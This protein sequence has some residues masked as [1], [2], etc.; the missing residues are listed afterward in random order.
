MSVNT[1]EYIY[2]IDRVQ[3]YVTDSGYHKYGKNDKDEMFKNMQSYLKNKYGDEFEKQIFEDNGGIY[4]TL[5]VDEKGKVVERQFLGKQSPMSRKGNVAREIN[6]NFLRYI[7]KSIEGEFK[8]EDDELP[9]DGNNN[10]VPPEIL[11]KYVQDLGG[12]PSYI[13]SQANY[14]YHELKE[15]IDRYPNEHKL[16]FGRPVTAITP[17]LTAVEVVSDIAVGNSYAFATSII[18]HLRV[19]CTDSSVEYHKN[20]IVISAKKYEGVYLTVYV[21]TNNTIRFQVKFGKAGLKDILNSN[22]IQRDKVKFCEDVSKILN[23]GK[24]M[25]EPLLDL[26]TKPLPS[27][28]ASRSETIDFIILL[29]QC[30][31]KN[32]KFVQEAFSILIFNGHLHNTSRKYTAIIKKMMDFGLL[33]MEKKGV[34]MLS[35]LAR[36]RLGLLIQFSR[37]LSIVSST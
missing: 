18:D 21:K 22:T 8:I 5:K 33:M 36:Q 24:T 1:T 35:E 26:C 2:S 9:L 34:Y 17:T 3:A 32:T 6:K 30:L 19:K 7:N 12:I 10:Y 25:L 31:P 37:T 16:I 23:G 29:A 11:K 15:V 4:E 27:Y 28:S 20:A 14:L 13:D